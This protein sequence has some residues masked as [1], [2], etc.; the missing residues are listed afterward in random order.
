M[1]TKES[2]NE[3]LGRQ[4]PVLKRINLYI[5]ISIPNIC[6]INVFNFELNKNKT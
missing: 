5:K 4:R 3:M 2:Q 1:G 6:L